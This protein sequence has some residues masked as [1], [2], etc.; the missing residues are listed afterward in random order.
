MKKTMLG[1][2]DNITFKQKELFKELVMKLKFKFD[3]EMIR[4]KSDW[5]QEQKFHQLE[6]ENLYSKQL[7]DLE[8]N[9]EK[10]LIEFTHKANEMKDKNQRLNQQVRTLQ[11]TTHTKQQTEQ[12]KQLEQLHKTYEEKVTGI[13]ETFTT[14]MDSLRK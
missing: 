14:Q 13:N 5:E 7:S 8:R 11:E 2:S 1:M 10:K 9:Y 12:S 3:N 4:T 6:K